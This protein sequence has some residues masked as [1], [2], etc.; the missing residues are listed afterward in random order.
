MT[1]RRYAVIVPVLLA[2]LFA[3][4]L[5]VA[6]TGS[7]GSARADATA[8]TTTVQ[9]STTGT[10]TSGGAGLSSSNDGLG[11]SSNSSGNS[12]NSWGSS[13]NSSGNSSSEGSIGSN[14]S[15]SSGDVLTGVGNTQNVDPG[16]RLNS[17]R[18]ILHN[19]ND[20][21]QEYARYCFT[22]DIQKLNGG[23]ASNIAA[24]GPD[25]GTGATASSVR[26]DEN[27][28]N[29]LIVGFT[30]GT[31]LKS[32]TTAQ[33]LGGVVT[34]RTGQG[35]IAD[36]VALDNART[37][38]SNN[39]T[40][41]P[42][43]TKIRVSP[44]LN[45]VQYYFDENLGHGTANAGDFGFYSQAGGYHAGSSIVSTYNN[46]VTVQFNSSDQVDTGQ[47]WF[48]TT[49]AVQDTNNI[50]NVLGVVGGST[51]APDLTSVN[52][53][54]SDT[55][56]SYRFDENVGN[57]SA[58]DFDL[59]TNDGTEI[60]ADSINTDGDTVYATFPSG[61]KDYPNDIVIAAV[62]PSNASDASDNSTSSTATDGTTP[63]IGAVNLGSS[64]VTRAGRTIGPNLTSVS[65]NANSQTITLTFDE[66]LD[67]SA[68]NTDASGIYLATSDNRLVQADQILSIQDNK[69]YVQANKTD[70]KSLKG[71]V[72]ESGAVT[73]KQGNNNALTTDIWGSGDTFSGSS[74][75]LFSHTV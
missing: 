18:V 30:P 25:P 21:Q 43:L 6:G 24:V 42:D 58:S 23:Q 51:N 34:N 55:L 44:N 48:A 39:R 45:Q 63:T 1:M 68:S 15:T 49:G 40:A 62:D 73:D 72:L 67:D 47:R 56:Y 60:Q 65:Q 9:S 14:G 36:S 74:N 71:I 57:V 64:N 16:N 32:Y 70:I 17:A 3:A 66:N 4:V 2:L 5:A 35:N 12:S 52:R 29:C 28:N 10:T 26:L 50:Q 22:D 27:N 7:S 53:L 33:V 59:Y 31:D 61:I 38:S 41:G 11:N 8:S 69:V 54:A 37:N 46:V 75:S 19:V 20:G 13:S